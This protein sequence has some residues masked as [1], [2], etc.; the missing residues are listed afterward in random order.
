VCSR[1]YCGLGGRSRC[2]V[3]VQGVRLGP[4]LDRIQGIMDCR[5]HV[6]SFVVVFV[7]SN[8]VSGTSIFGRASAEAN[9]RR[10][11]TETSRPDI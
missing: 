7:S 6:I 2:R 8:C 4:S 5:M 9:K 1:S 3:G 10:A 11:R